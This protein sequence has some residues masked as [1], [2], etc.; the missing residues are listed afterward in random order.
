MYRTEDQHGAPGH[1]PHHR[2]VV[3]GTLRES[4]V[5]HRNGRG[6]SCPLREY[7][8]FHV[9]LDHSK[10]LIDAAVAQCT[11]DCVAVFDL[12]GTCTVFRTMPRSYDTTEL[13][14]KHWGP[15]CPVHGQCW[16]GHRSAHAA[17]KIGVA[18]LLGAEYHDLFPM[19]SQAEKVAHLRRILDWLAQLLE[20][21][22][23]L[24]EF[25]QFLEVH[26]VSPLVASNGAAQFV[27]P[28]LEMLGLSHLPR[29]SN[30]LELEDGVDGCTFC[31]LHG[32]EGLSK[33]HVVRR[34]RKTHGKNVRFGFGDSGG[35]KGLAL[36]TAEGAQGNVFAR[37]GLA[38]ERLCRE[39]LELA[40]VVAGRWQ[41]FDNFMEAVPVVQ[42]CC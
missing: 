39:D 12:D 11:H 24:P 27:D 10:R 26:Q 17:G 40:P 30:W 41:P 19:K 28:I 4:I 13:V 20:V 25:L 3:P 18:G 2:V 1:G 14:N 35:D 29:V 16:Y 21:A 5:N 31:T 22:P 15:A 6:H 8:N 33:A 36:A 38:L 32:P 23:G 37:R 42:E 34:M 7:R 9:D